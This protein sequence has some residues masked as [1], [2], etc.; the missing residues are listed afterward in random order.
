MDNLRKKSFH[1]V[2]WDFSGKIIN[3]G[4][5]FVLSIF[6]ARLLSPED[7]GLLAMASVFIGFSESFM[8]FGLTSALVQKKNTT[9]GQYSTV[10]YLNLIIATILMVTLFLSSGYIADFFN[11]NE[12]INIVRVLSAIFIISAVNLV[13]RA[14]LIKNLNF[15]LLTNATIIGSVIAGIVGVLMA[16]SGFGVWS[17]V[18]K[19]LLVGIIQTIIIWIY[20][21]WRPQKYFNLKEI[22]EHW[23]FGYKLFLSGLISNIYSKIDI[24]VIG[25]L[26][27]ATELGYYYRAKS[28]NQLIITYTSDSLSKVLFPVFSEIQDDIDRVKRVLSKSL[29]VISF[30]VFGLIGL[31]FLTANDLIIILFGEKW[32]QSIVF[33]KILLF[34]AYAYPISSI[35]VTV[36]SGLGN[37]AAFL[38]LEVIKRIFLTIAIFIGFL[39]GIEG[40]LY[41]LVI[42]S[43]FGVSL[44]MWYVQKQIDL[45]IFY[46][47]KDV[48]KY[49]IPT[50]FITVIVHFI[51]YN[52]QQMLLLHLLSAGIL[53]LILYFTI[54][55][56]FK[57]KGYVIFHGLIKNLFDNRKSVLKF[58]YS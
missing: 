11:N 23:I 17:L 35:L 33:F 57:T 49:A 18:A 58:L 15:K 54:N 22:K 44:N 6:L 25:K 9:S 19:T 16:F 55:I 28:L 21:P 51:T 42:V 7:F 30:L 1:A 31:L 53:S 13:Q 8:D 2:K 38:K 34:S 12:I 24:L 36:I 3:Q 46:Q 20:S 43:I 41:A 48:F 52:I 29:N 27:N 32:I 47:Y 45:S 56:L 37:S 39:F 26:F 4:A 14:F 50:L 10:F 5:T 40:Y